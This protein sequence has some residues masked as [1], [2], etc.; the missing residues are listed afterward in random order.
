MLVF[1]GVFALCSLG[2]L[3]TRPGV[4]LVPE[5]LFRCRVAPVAESAFSVLHDVALVDNRNAPP[6]ELEGVLDGGFNQP[7]AAK[8]R[9]G[10]DADA[11]LHQQ[12]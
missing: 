1:G 12:L 10:F 3:V 6:L 11:D 5:E 2:P 9:D 8:T 4:D 7:H